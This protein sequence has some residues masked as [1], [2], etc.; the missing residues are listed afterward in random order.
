MPTGDVVEEEGVGEARGREMQWAFPY[1]DNT[2]FP[3]REQRGMCV[4]GVLRLIC[5]TYT[6][7]LYCFYYLYTLSDSTSASCFYEATPSIG[8]W[9][10]VVCTAKGGIDFA[11]KVWKMICR[12]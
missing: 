9:L 1:S 3:K 10:V 8:S 7:I 6:Q 11:H 4:K 12:G 2:N 5:K